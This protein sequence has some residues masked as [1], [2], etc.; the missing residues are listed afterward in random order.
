MNVESG[1]Q[2]CLQQEKIIMSDDQSKTHEDDPKKKIFRRIRKYPT[3]YLKR[4][5]LAFKENPTSPEIIEMLVHCLTPQ[6]SSHF[7]EIT[8][9]FENEEL[10][11]LTNYCIT[12]SYEMSLSC[13]DFLREKTTKLF[14][15]FFWS[16]QKSFSDYFKS[17]PECIFDQKVPEN[18]RIAIIQILEEILK[19]TNYSKLSQE[20]LQKYEKFLLSTDLLSQLTDSTI[21][22]R[23]IGSLVSLVAAIFDAE[24]PCANVIFANSVAYTILLNTL[25]IW[26]TDKY[27]IESCFKCL[28]AI[29]KCFYIESEIF[30]ERLILKTKEFFENA[31]NDLPKEVVTAAATFW[32]DVAAIE[33]DKTEA[34]YIRNF[35]F[36]KAYTSLAPGFDSS[37]VD[38]GKNIPA[39]YMNYCGMAAVELFD[40][41]CELILGNECEN[42]DENIENFENDKSIQFIATETLKALYRTVPTSIFQVLKLKFE[43][44]I[45]GD[46]MHQKAACFLLYAASEKISE[47]SNPKAFRDSVVD[48]LNSVLFKMCDLFDSDVSCLKSRSMA[49][50]VQILSN[51]PQSLTMFEDQTKALSR[52]LDSLLVTKNCFSLQAQEDNAINISFVLAYLIGVYDQSSAKNP[53]KPEKGLFDRIYRFLMM[54]FMDQ[55]T[56]RTPKFVWSVLQA[57]NTLI[58]SSPKAITTLR[59]ILRNFIDILSRLE[60]SNDEQSINIRAPR[61]CGTI[62]VLCLRLQEHSKEFVH[63]ISD[64]LIKFF[65]RDDQKVVEGAAFIYSELFDVQKEEITKFIDSE[66]II[67]RAT[68]FFNTVHSDCML[69]STPNLISCI[70][71][72]AKKGPPNK[73]DE[74][75]TD[76]L[77]YAFN[78]DYT[79]D[80]IKTEIISSLTDVINY[81]NEENSAILSKYNSMFFQ[82]INDLMKY[83]YATETT[84]DTKQAE[85]TVGVAC[86]ATL[87][88]GKAYCADGIDEK[89]EPKI[90]DLIGVLNQAASSFS[91]SVLME[92]LDATLPV[93][94]IFLPKLSE[95]SK[96]IITAGVNRNLIS[97]GLKKDKAAEHASDN[98]NVLHQ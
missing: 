17:T 60:K 61:I 62:T 75:L 68:K 92:S 3:L 85:K 15:Y 82:A 25:N 24:L 45:K 80:E 52:I 16:N 96:N 98:K 2:T 56:Y 7:L 32:Q 34:H 57:V 54:K 37:Q 28:R 14:S 46:T 89:M 47:R 93:F 8:S 87:A 65:E 86:D 97:L 81:F 1:F 39:E 90:V 11:E 6:N 12:K 79:Q 55:Q 42:E 59:G 84:A 10:K 36:N 72:H 53:L 49:V 22:K 73:A 51:Y 31:N 95:R 83:S 69:C 74:D 63:E 19:N 43:E 44:F 38:F 64:L 35:L 50:F 71:K 58:S 77:F 48:F 88:Y 91:D 78:S 9:F 13:D 29:I 70:Y 41:L 30:I 4:A 76:S 27:V 40:V 94:E 5:I 67:K 18:E 26:R 20:M 66:R 23:I 21:S 33:F